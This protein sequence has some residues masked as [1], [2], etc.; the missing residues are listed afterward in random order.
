[1]S[2]ASRLS[3]P[4][5]V[6]PGPCPAIPTP[7]SLGRPSAPPHLLARGLACRGPGEPRG[8][9]GLLER[10]CRTPKSWMPGTGPGVLVREGPPAGPR[11]WGT[12]KEMEVQAKRGQRAVRVTSLP[13]LRQNLG[14]GSSAG[15]RVMG[16]KEAV[17]QPC[18]CIRLPSPAP[19]SP[20]ARCGQRL[21]LPV[22][23]DPGFP[24][25]EGAPALRSGIPST[26]S[27]AS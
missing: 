10:V 9:H 11:P 26:D 1:M 18:P 5:H 25:A 12:R 6:A 27:A 17:V 16:F 15:R 22:R 20:G 21:C 8:T 23:W 3:S 24:R 2:P 4:S 19:C 14:R 7:G 13:A